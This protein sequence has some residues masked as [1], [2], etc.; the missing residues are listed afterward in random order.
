MIPDKGSIMIID[1]EG[2]EEAYI[3]GTAKLPVFTNLQ[4]KTIALLSATV[5]KRALNIRQVAVQLGSSLRKH[6]G[7][8][9]LG[10]PYRFL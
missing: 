3:S 9:R 4:K 2:T 7:G 8:S 1:V 6:R 5:E 10:R